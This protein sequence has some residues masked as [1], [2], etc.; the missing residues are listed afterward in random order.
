[1]NIRPYTPDDLAGIERLF[2]EREL[3]FDRE[4]FLWKKRAPHSLSMIGESGGRV[5]AHYC[6]IEMPLLPSC[7]AGFAVDGIFAKSHSQISAIQ[8][9]IGHTAEAAAD[10]GIQ[11]LIAFANDRMKPVKQFLGWRPIGRYGWR[12][13]RGA[14]EVG[15]SGPFSRTG[16]GSAA[17]EEWR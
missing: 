6:V 2:E 11:V 15:L 4:L 5:V 3:P 9:L 10:C 1:M 14:A 17:Y 12:R 13:S 7:R 8:Q 16:A